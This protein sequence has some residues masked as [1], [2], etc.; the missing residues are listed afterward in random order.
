VTVKEWVEGNP[1]RVWRKS[2]K[3]SI[4]EVAAMM[5]VSH[6]TIHMWENGSTF[7][8]RERLTGILKLLSNGD[9]D[10]GPAFNRW[11]AWWDRKRVVTLEDQADRLGDAGNQRVP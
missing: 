9:A 1:L 10:L 6:V 11:I 5:N 7:P 3:Y 8:R 2:K 4:M